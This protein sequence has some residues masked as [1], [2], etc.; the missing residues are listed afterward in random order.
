MKIFTDVAALAAS[1]LIAGQLV[2]TKGYTTAGDGGQGRYLIKTA[3]Q[4]ATDGDTIDDTGAGFT[5]A[6][7]NVAVLQVEGSVNVKQFGA[8]GDGA[9]DGT[10]IQ[11]ALDS[12][13]LGGTIIFPN[14]TYLATATLTMY[15]NQTIDLEGST[16][17]FNIIGKH[18]CLVTKDYC[19][20]RNGTVANITT[21]TTV[22]GA[23]WQQPICIGFSNSLTDGVH[24]V[25]IENIQV[26]TTSP[27]GNLIFAFGDTYN[28]IV[29]NITVPPS[30]SAG[31]P[32]GGHWSSEPGGDET[33]G[34]NHP[35]NL[36]FRNI[37]V[38]A[39]SYST[40]AGT[41]YFSA[42]RKI[43]VE[44]I[45]IES[46]ATGNALQIFAGDHGF[47]Y[48]LDVSA[49]EEGTVASIRNITARCQ[50]GFTVIM[51]DT[52]SGASIW[53]SKIVFEGCNLT[54]N[55]GTVSGN[56]G[57]SLSGTTRVVF[58]DNIFRDFYYG[59]FL[60]S[61]VD[62]IEFAHNVFLDSYITGMD[63][64]T[65][66]TNKNITIS[67]NTFS[68]TNVAAAT[69][70][71]INLGGNI[72]NVQIHG[73]VFNSPAATR[74]VYSDSA[75]PAKNVKVINNH[76]LDCGGTPFVFG[77]SSSVDIC[78]LFNG[79]SLD[80]ALVSNIRGGQEM[81]PYAVSSAQN[82]TAPQKLYFGSSA[83]NYEPSSQGDIV[84]NDGVSA[85]GT[86]GW[87]CTVSGTPGTWKTFGA[88]TA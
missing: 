88:V 7:A 14:G 75:S 54:C 83:P 22:Y 43:I 85:S 9:A 78:S 28:I 52:L 55:T 2:E 80:S 46:N 66:S 72:D 62:S 42:C 44:N 56:N 32:F 81:V 11:F 16:L 27:A 23:E 34:T 68:G 63:L 70:Y 12:L 86:V 26:S 61:S 15:P 38:G 8:T 4:A 73:N 29:Q 69:G 53:P 25:L 37:K 47:L 10:A 64:D 30:S 59:V 87:V 3:A 24:D 79:N 39:M 60:G 31:E 67:N 13:P 33:L 71:D 82:S 48:A 84:W 77:N 51:R 49:K 74:S 57:I 40:S 20:V 19:T 1:K 18:R 21:D 36:I 58:K 45:E 5:L 6:N 65:V 35:N 76:V 17:N 41:F 50:K